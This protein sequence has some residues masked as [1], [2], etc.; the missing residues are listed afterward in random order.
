MSIYTGHMMGFNNSQW[1]WTAVH[2]FWPDIFQLYIVVLMTEAL[3][4]NSEEK[5]LELGSV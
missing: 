5:V 1:R 2:W 3:G 4:L